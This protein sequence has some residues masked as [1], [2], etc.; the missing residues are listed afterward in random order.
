MV[1]LKS[2]TNSPLHVRRNDVELVMVALAVLFAITFMTTLYVPRP[3]VA[4]SKEILW[5]SDLV[6]LF[7]L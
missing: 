5:V 1:V 4:R 2:A 7:T 6:L 3:G